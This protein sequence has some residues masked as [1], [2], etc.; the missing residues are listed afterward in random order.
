MR[1]TRRHGIDGEIG[2]AIRDARMGAG[3]RQAQLARVLGLTQGQASRLEGGEHPWTLRHLQQACRWLGSS[4][5]PVL[6]VLAVEL[7]EE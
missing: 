4:S 1:K 2:W 5:G 6:E 7:R 3:L